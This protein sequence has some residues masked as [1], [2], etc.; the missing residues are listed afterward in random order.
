LVKVSAAVE[1]GMEGLIAAHIGNYYFCN[2]LAF[3]GQREHH[4]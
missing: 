2:K 3:I 1:E 4:E